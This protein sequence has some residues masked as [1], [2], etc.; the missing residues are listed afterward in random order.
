MTNVT[1]PRTAPPFDCPN[2]ATVLPAGSTACDSCGIRL[3]GPLALR[4]WQV[5][6]EIEALTAEGGALRRRLLAPADAEELRLSTHAQVPAQPPAYTPLPPAP[7]A[8]GGPSGQQV[9]L[10]I[11]ALM[12]LSGAAFFL[13]VVWGRI[14]VGGQTAVMV[15]LTGLAA[16]GAVAA[17]GR[18]LGAAAETAAVIATGLV[19]LDLTAAHALGLAGLDR[20]DGATY[21]SGAGLLGAGVLVGFDRWLP[22]TV[23]GA[24]ARR[25]FVYRPAVTVL[26]CVALWNMLVVGPEWTGLAASAAAL[27]LT[28]ASAGVAVAALRLDPPTGGGFRASVVAP[29]VSTVVALA[30]HLGLAVSSGYAPGP[31]VERY[32]AMALLLVLPV[33][34]LCLVHLGPWGDRRSVREAAYVVAALGTFVAAGVPVMALPREVLAV[35]ALLLG[36]G[37]GALL[38][39]PLVGVTVRTVAASWCLAGGVVLVWLVWVL[40]LAVVRTGLDLSRAGAHAP[41]AGVWVAAA[42]MFGVAVA[43]AVAAVARRSVMWAGAAQVAAV[44]GVWTLLRGADHEA[45]LVVAVSVALLHVAAGAWARW[46]HRFTEA[47]GFE[48]LAAVGAFVHAA[49]AIAVASDLS[50]VAYAS[51]W[52]LLGVAVLAYAGLPRRLEVAHLGALMVPVGLGVLLADAGVETVE[53]YTVSAVLLLAAVGAVRWRRSPEVSTLVTMGPAAVVGVLPSLAVGVGGDEVVR[54]VLV[55]LVGL[56]LLVAG[57]AYRWLAPVLVGVVALGTVAVT[58]GGPLVEYVPNFVLLM[59]AGAVALAVGV[60]WEAAVAA[61]RRGFVWLGTLR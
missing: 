39:R 40:D 10:G 1:E 45:V 42:P 16:A 26:V 31:A 6:R 57:L 30:T 35:A 46:V 37:T 59:G 22:R 36:A 60:A 48:A 58:Q 53:A 11:G 7:P 50:V 55:T 5:G 28:A 43:T 12:L 4:L 18:R 25:V 29:V 2:C 15:V 19:W 51:T 32:G 9:L 17:T 52:L 33:A 61:G 14:G 56:V 49:V 23:A 44:L 20:L 34:A 54:L 24:P 38:W 8:P 13:S 3:S 47:V 21:W 41:E 27:V